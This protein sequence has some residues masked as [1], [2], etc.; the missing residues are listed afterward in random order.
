MRT[1]NSSFTHNL[2][3]NGYYGRQ[4]HD[5]SVL[6]FLRPPQTTRNGNTHHSRY[7]FD[8]R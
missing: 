7:N 3:L 6:S 2:T 1:Q 4:N 8:T 5:K